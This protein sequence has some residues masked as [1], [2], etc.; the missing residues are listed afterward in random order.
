MREGKEF[1]IRQSMNTTTSGG[2]P[3][4]AGFPGKDP[5]LTQKQRKLLG[6]SKPHMLS[7]QNELI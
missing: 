4:G 2:G 7:K 1:I 3:D 5:A 6:M